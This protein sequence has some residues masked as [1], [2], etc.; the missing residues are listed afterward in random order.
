MKVLS[1][2]FI[3]YFLTS[4]FSALVNFCSR[5]FYS[6]FWDYTYAVTIAYFT[7]M[8]VNFAFTT[9]F[10][11]GRYEN[12]RLFNMFVK[13]SSVAIVG[14][15]ITVLASLSIRNVLLYLDPP[16]S[17]AIIESVSHLSGI[18]IAFI[19]SFLGHKFFT[20]RH[21]GFLSDILEVFRK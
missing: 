13:F 6:I 1:S 11:F 16:F 3:A 12:S 18:G 4:G 9:K 21:T 8:I 7:G 17:L 5:I 2:R 10:V 20:Y 15:I 14:L 19:A